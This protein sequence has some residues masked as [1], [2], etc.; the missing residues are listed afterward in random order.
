MIALDALL[1]FDEVADDRS[2]DRLRPVLLM[3]LRWLLFADGVFGGFFDARN[4]TFIFVDA[5]QMNIHE[6]L[7]HERIDGLRLM[8]SGVGGGVIDDDDDVGSL[9]SVVG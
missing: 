2:A 9:H 1:L 7:M 6:E 4:R 3:L 8:R 5:P